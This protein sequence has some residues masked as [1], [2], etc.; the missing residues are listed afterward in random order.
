MRP[1]Y[2]RMMDRVETIPECG[3][4]IFTGAWDGGGYG[5]VST[6]RGSS[7]AK[8]HRLSYEE[9]NGKIPDGFEVCHRCDT[10]ACVNPEHLFIG[11]RT[12]NMRDCSKKGRLSPKSLLNLKPGAA[13]YR[14]AGPLSEGE[15][16]KHVI[17]KQ[18]TAN[19]QPWQRP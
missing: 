5:Q 2:E 10:P 4:W 14:G 16:R 13:G 11:S 15:L 9:N 18:S 3:C 17:F 6:K 12:D 19:R 8:S 7:P 1:A